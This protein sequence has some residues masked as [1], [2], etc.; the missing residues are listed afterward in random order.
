M[1]VY[2]DNCSLNRPFDD[3][4]QLIVHLETEAKLYI[5]DKIKKGEYEFIWSYVS[6]YENAANPSP[7]R[8]EAIGEWRNIALFVS[9]RKTT[10][11]STSPTNY[12]KLESNQKILFTLRLRL[13]RNAIIL[14][15]RIY[16]FSTK[17]SAASK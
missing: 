11:Y 15:P 7:E 10:E 13:I 3:Q 17:K 9:F 16:V 6:D 14:L 4:T 1:R 5:Q 12:R 2:L 8:R